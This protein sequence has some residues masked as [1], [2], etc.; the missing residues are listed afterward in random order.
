MTDNVLAGQPAES[1][2]INPFQDID[3]HLQ[4]ALRLKR[5]VLLR[6]IPGYDDF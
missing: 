2:I 4:T 1:D 6:Q 5:Q 3:C